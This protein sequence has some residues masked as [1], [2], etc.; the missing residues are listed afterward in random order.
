MV[1]LDIL[2]RGL[3]F[4]VVIPAI[5][6]RESIPA[7]HAR[8]LLSGIHLRLFQMDPRQQLAGMTE[9]RRLVLSQVYH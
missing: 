7:R 5:S 2:Y 3:I 6:S 1:L 4:R 8:H 9:W